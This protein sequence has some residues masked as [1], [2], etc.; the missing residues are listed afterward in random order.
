MGQGEADNTN[1]NNNDF[2]LSRKAASVYAIL[3][4]GRT[5]TEL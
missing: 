3:S 5:L 1:N 4:E 2:D